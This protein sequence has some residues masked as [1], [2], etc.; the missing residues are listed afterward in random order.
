MADEGHLPH[1]DPFTGSSTAPD[2]T[3][4]IDGVVIAT[5]IGVRD[6]AALIHHLGLDD[7]DACVLASSAR[8]LGLSDLGSELAVVFVDGDPDQPLI[9][10]KLERFGD[11]TTRSGK[12]ELVLEAERKITI[13]C[14]RSS[15]CLSRDGRL[16]IRGQHLLSRAASVNRI[17]GGVIQ[18]N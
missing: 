1:V 15:I 2:T 4:R 6:G 18:L 10:G 13:R 12:R 5:L 3:A 9:L 17:R 16:E 11:R 14:G 7:D 8:P